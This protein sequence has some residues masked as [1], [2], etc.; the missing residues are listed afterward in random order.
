MWVHVDRY[1][2]RSCEGVIERIFRGCSWGTARVKAR[3]HFVYVHAFTYDSVCMY[4]CTRARA[5]APVC[6]R[7]CVCEY[8]CA[9]DSFFAGSPRVLVHVAAVV[10]VCVQCAS[11]TAENALL[12]CSAQSRYNF[13][14]FNFPCCTRGRSTFYLEFHY[15]K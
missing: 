4:V 11:L 13:D 9:L 6:V 3:A 8:A 5:R 2:M 12:S 1:A 15:H 10:S 14:E 7:M